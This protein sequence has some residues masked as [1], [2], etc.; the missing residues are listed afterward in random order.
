[1]AANEPENN[2]FHENIIYSYINLRIKF[3][4]KH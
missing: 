2:F 1:M 4:G 3:F